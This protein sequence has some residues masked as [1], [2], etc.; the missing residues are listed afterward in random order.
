[1]NL[2]MNAVT[3]SNLARLL[4]SETLISWYNPIVPV[5]VGLDSV[6]SVSS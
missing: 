1:M 5:V 4:W 2:G 3:K 6:E